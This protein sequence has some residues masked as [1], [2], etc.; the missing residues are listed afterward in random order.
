MAVF[1]SCFQ[2]CTAVCVAPA[3]PILLTSAPGVNKAE[4]KTVPVEEHQGKSESPG[5]SSPWKAPKGKKYAPFE[6]EGTVYWRNSANFLYATIAGNDEEFGEWVG[7]YKDGRIDESAE[8][9]E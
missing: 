5:E 8:E 2:K 3:I 7:A 9:P 6:H 1:L 4:A